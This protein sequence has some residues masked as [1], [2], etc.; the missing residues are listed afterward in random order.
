MFVYS[1]R[2]YETYYHFFSTL[3]PRIR[4][5]TAVGTDGEQAIVKS[6]EALLPDNLIHLHCFMHMR[7]NIRHKLS[8][9]LLPQSDVK[10]SQVKC[11]VNA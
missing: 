1:E 2:T 9:M 7:D 5:I 8:D 10:Y 3:E 6:L 4:D 11:G